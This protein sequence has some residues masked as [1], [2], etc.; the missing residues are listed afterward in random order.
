MILQLAESISAVTQILPLVEK[1]PKKSPGAK[2][3]DKVP[4]GPLSGDDDT[5]ERQRRETVTEATEKRQKKKRSR[6]GGSKGGR[7]EQWQRHWM[8]RMTCRF[9]SANIV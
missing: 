6:E 9:F 4:A 1:S 5:R 7:E 3:P 8:Q 2:R